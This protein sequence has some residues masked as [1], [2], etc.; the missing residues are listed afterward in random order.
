ML[1]AVQG[2][3][4]LRLWKPGGR[5]VGRSMARALVL[6]VLLST[7]LGFVPAGTTP[8]SSMARARADLLQ[9]LTNTGERH[10][11][12]V[13]YSPKHNVHEEW[14]YNRA[15]LEEAPVVWARDRTPD[16]NH[17]LVEYFEGRKVWLLKADQLP[18]TLEAY[19]FS[20][21]K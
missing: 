18:P 2:L 1:L 20:P 12:F 6:A 13:R 10:L 17:R 14:V 15:N 4:R 21:E 11:V 3:R 16:E 5:R 7:L 19:G 9:T 8:P